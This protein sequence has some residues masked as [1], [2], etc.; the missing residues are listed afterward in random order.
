M[1][2]NKLVVQSDLPPLEFSLTTGSQRIGSGRQCEICIPHPEVPAHAVTVDCRNNLLLLENQSPYALYLGDEIVES[3]GRCAWRIG[4]PLLLTRSVSLKVLGSGAPEPEHSEIPGAANPATENRR[5]EAETNGTGSKQ[6]TTTR[7]VVQ[8]GVIVL[9]LLSGLFM[10]RDAPSSDAKPTDS[11][12]DLTKAIVSKRSVTSD[13]RE[14][15]QRLQTAW[16]TE[17]R[18]QQDERKKVIAA[19]QQV[20]D[21]RLVR[22]APTDR[23]TIPGRVKVF[24]TQ[25]LGRFAL[26]TTER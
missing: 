21:H 11:M 10:L 22:N 19:Y 12:D 5:A 8:I 25:R 4:V 9:C 6:S 3:R 15:L 17:Q 14:L 16:I 23:E 20:L 24:V 13:E 1:S 2:T 18:A 7:N 26:K